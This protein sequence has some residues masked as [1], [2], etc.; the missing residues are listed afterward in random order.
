MEY[1]VVDFKIEC[2]PEHLQDAKDLLA[3]LAGECGCESFEETASGL[4]GYIQKELLTQDAMHQLEQG[5]QDFPLPSAKITYQIQEAEDKDWNQEWEETGFSPIVIDDKIVIYDAKHASPASLSLKP[6]QIGIGI[7]ARLAFGTGNHQTTRMMISRL[8]E[9]PLA[10][11]KVLDCGCGTGILGITASKLGAASIVGYDIDEWSVRNAD[12][13][14]ALNG[15]KEM[16]VLQGNVSVLQHT[17]GL[18]DIVMA[19]INRNILLQDMQHF[20]DV[21]GEGAFLI[22]SGFYDEDA[23]TLIGKAHEYGLTVCGRKT[24]DHWTCL[25]FAHDE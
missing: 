21:M 9:T 20:H 24:E 1:N 7:E 10:G 15:V 25:K 22:I 13:N 18:F 14:A 16:T 5:I 6:T 17:S 12:H 23:E 2:A 11:K 19:N 8:E 4:K 3:D